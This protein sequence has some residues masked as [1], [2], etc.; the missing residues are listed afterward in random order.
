MKISTRLFFE[1]AHRLVDYDG[2]CKRIHG[3]SWVVDVE[4]NSEDDLDQTGFLMDFKDVQQVIKGFDHMLILKECEEN[5]K[6]AV[7]IPDDWILWTKFNPTCENF[8][9][10]FKSEILSYLDEFTHINVTIKVYE[11]YKPEKKSYAEA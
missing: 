11:S 5:R 6:I 9:Q 10:Y 4:I 2:A 3:H 8:A 7:S 1:A